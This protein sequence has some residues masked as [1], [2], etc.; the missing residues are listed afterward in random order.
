MAKSTIKNASNEAFDVEKI[1]RFTEQELNKLSTASGDLP[2]CY[3]LGTD[4][5]VGKYRVL[6][7]DEQVWRVAEGSSQLFDFFNR[8]DAI[9][10][11]IALHKRQY[12][13]AQDIK[14]CDS[15]LNRL[16][17]D[18]ALYRIRYKKSIKNS[19]YWGEEF[20]STR[21]QETMNRISQAKKE[22]KKNLDLAKYIKL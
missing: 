5:L 7:I 11:C 13:L 20:Y 12:K 21:Y 4:V 2:L 16:E 10:Y 15:L 22:I 17:F 6:K 1:K 19:D 14:D 18:A 8:K 9:F 3:Q